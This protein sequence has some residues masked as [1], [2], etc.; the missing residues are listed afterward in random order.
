MIKRQKGAF[1]AI[2]GLACRASESYCMV[3]GRLWEVNQQLATFMGAERPLLCEIWGSHGRYVGL[4]G[5]NIV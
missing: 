1:R 3:Q 5:C 4:L 2:C